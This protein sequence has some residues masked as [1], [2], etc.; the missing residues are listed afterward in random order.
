LAQIGARP[1]PAR[2]LLVLLIIALVAAAHLVKRPELRPARHTHAETTQS[3]IFGRARVIDG[4]TIDVAGARIRLE[5]IDAPE[6]E[7]SC[8]DPAGTRWSCGRAAARELRTHLAGQALRCETSGVD[9]YRRLLATCALPDGSEVN[10]WLVRE[11]WALA[12]GFSGVYRAE[13]AEAQAARR[14]IWS[15]NFLPP[16]EWRRRHM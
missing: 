4:D 1:L 16:W 3:A 5:G 15:G 10:A 8:A 13:E 9:G 12:Y 11:G 14:G 7:Q 2:S 6:I